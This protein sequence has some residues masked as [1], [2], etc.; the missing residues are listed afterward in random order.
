MVLNTWEYK[1]VDTN[2]DLEVLNLI[3]GRG[4]EL[5]VGTP[6]GYIFKRLKGTT[7]QR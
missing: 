4:W 1:V 6:K 2:I 5:V 7:N 3:G